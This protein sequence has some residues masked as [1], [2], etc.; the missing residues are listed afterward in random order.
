M[1]L[2]VVDSQ[3]GGK[4]LLL[5]GYIYSKHR[6]AEEKIFWRWQKFQNNCKG[7]AVSKGND[8]QCIQEHNHAP[9]SIDVEKEKINFNFQSAALNTQNSPRNVINECL[10]GVSNDA[11]ATLPKLVS[12]E[13]KVSRT[14]RIS[15]EQS[16]PQSLKD[17]AI[18][19]KLR[20]N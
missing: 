17:I 10:V 18:L 2:S 4:K 14:R 19:E 6:E 20:F 1:T 3:R 16:I 8:A 7:R 15:F 9:C 12:M 11:I 13:R 5:D